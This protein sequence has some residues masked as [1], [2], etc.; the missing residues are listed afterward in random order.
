MSSLTCDIVTPARM[1]YTQECYM[2]VVPGEEGSMGF[3]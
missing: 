3:M 2:V 1:L